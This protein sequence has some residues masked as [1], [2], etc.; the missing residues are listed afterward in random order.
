MYFNA[1]KKNYY[2][3]PSKD[4]VNEMDSKYYFPDKPYASGDNTRMTGNADNPASE[5]GRF[6]I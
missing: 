6:V 2:R 5:R 4:S 3:F 1:S